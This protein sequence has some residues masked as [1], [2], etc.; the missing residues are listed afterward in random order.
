MIYC[1]KWRLRST[2]SGQERYGNVEND[3]Q[4]KPSSAWE[5]HKKSSR[6]KLVFLFPEKSMNDGGHL[7]QQKFFELAS[8]HY[9]TEFVTYE[10]RDGSVRHLNEA[11]RT[12]R[13]N[14]DTIYCVHYGP[15]IRKLC[16]RLQG[17]RIV[18]FAHSTGWG[19]K[20]PKGV[21]I[22][23]VSKHSQAYW[24]RH[25]PYNSGYCLPNIVSSEF[26]LPQHNNASDRS[27]DVI[28]VKRKMSSYLI[29]QLVPVL[30]Q[31]CTVKVIDSW[32]DDLAIELKNSKVFLYD[33]TEH[34]NKKRVSEG[35]GLPPL[36]ALACGCKVFSCLNDALSDYLDPGRNCTQLRIGSLALDVERIIAAV[37]SW[38]AAPKS[39]DPAHGYRQAGVGQKM[40]TIF[41]EVFDM[42][43]SAFKSSCQF[44]QNV[45][46]ETVGEL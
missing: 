8:E 32:V 9:D 4:Y 3:T 21:P 13:C 26:S 28:I 30:E 45:N 31:H 42:F 43:E 7:A 23:S 38:Q 11:L 6:N 34:W 20:L 2:D 41:D 17:R 37:N 24:G 36:E 10:K 44:R 25:A 1:F 12:N 35:F 14:D 39:G 5:N 29:K 27:I 22:V 33:S 15:H 16:R 46:F 40:K 19:F 18:Y